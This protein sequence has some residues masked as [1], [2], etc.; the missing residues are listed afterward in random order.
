MTTPIRKTRNA[1]RK[2]D[3]YIIT[4]LFVRIRQ[5]VETTRIALK[6]ITDEKP[7][8]QTQ[9]VLIS[10]SAMALLDILSA[11]DE[12]QNIIKDFATQEQA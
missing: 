7:G 8:P 5:A 6:R 9:A 11:L 1:R 12:L 10:K 4:A 2:L 3:G